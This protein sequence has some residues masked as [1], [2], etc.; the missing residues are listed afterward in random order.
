MV[1]QIKLNDLHTMPGI[2]FGLWKNTDAA[3]CI[4]SIITALQAGFRHFD[5]AQI[6]GNEQFLGTALKDS[7]IPRQEIFIT[8]KISLKNFI[9]VEHSFEESLAKLQTDYADLVLLHY[10]LTGLRRGAWHKLETLKKSGKAKSIG[11]SNYTIR[12]LEGLLKHCTVKPA[13]N[14]VE[15][16]VF[17]QQPE[18][19]EYCRQ[20]DIAVEAYSPLAHGQGMDD[21]ELVRIAQK[22][23]KTAAQVMLRW[24]VEVGTTPLPK[25]VTPERIKQNIE[26]FDFK[27]DET[28]MAD[29]LKLNKDLRTCWDPTLTP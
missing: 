25:S 13:V 22:Y 5:T 18:L 28:D 23:G 8:T 4:A 11:V 16:H 10:P 3:E 9:K 15:L 21:P 12:H 17:L 26:I 1:P 27:L 20:H 6:Y 2:G 24:C 7:G 14:Q 19:L 29:I